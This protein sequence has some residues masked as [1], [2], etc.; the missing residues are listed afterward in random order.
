MISTLQRN[1]SSSSIVALKLRDQVI[2]AVRETLGDSIL[3]SG[4][5]DTSIIA[6]VVKSVLKIKSIFKGFTITLR[7]VTSPDE[8]Y[9]TLISSQFKI[10]HRIDS[11][12]I[13]E[14]EDELPEV[15]SVLKTFDPME[16]RNSVVAYLGMKKA[17]FEG[18]SKIMTGDASDELF[19]GYN[20]VFKKPEAEARKTLSHLWKVMHFSSISL[21]KSLGIEARLP[22]L[23]PPLMEYAMHE[24]DFRL[25]IG[26]KEGQEFGKFILRQAFE[27]LLPSNITWRAKTPIEFGSGTTILPKL[28][29]QMINDSEFIEKKKEYFERDHVRLRDKEQL[30][31]YEIFRRV[32]GPPTTLDRNIRACP[33]CNTNVHDDAS[34]FCTTCGEY[35][36]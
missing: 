20:F 36:I 1:E 24:I 22:F 12:S 14:L 21:A 19:A 23:Y 7:G 34:T 2:K 11:I 18:Y 10:P 15:I 28:Y 32:N 6:A 4:G 31:Y 3:L 25:L 33:A 29:S 26:E 9:S 16:I 8:E 13:A 27:D 30:K 35:P 17:R 5:L